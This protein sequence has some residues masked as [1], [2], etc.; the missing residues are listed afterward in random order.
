MNFSIMALKKVEPFG[1]EMDRKR[2]LDA[3]KSPLYIRTRKVQR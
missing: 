2:Y 1:L 3:L